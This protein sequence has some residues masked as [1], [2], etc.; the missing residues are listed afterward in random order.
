VVRILRPDGE[1]RGTIRQYFDPQSRITDC[2]PG[3]IPVSGKD[4]EVKEKDAVESAVI[5]VDGDYLAE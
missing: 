3:A 4:Y 1:A 2:M 5:G